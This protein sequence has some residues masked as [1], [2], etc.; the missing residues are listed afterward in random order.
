M[1]STT[2]ALAATTALLAWACGGG[3]ESA[4]ED[5]MDRM[6]EEHEGDRPVAAA[7]ADGE[8]P[9]AVE[10][11]EVQYASVG[12][13]EVTGYLATPEG[14]SD[15]VPG[16]IVIHEWWGLNDNIRAMAE[17]LA[18]EGY[19]ALAVDLYHGESATTSDGA[20]ELVRSVDE[21]QA[22]DNLRQAYD[23]L[24]ERGA[25]R[26]GAIGWCFGGGW[27]LQTALL[28][29][30]ELDADVIYY[31]RLV[32]TPDVL[33]ALEMPIMGHFGAEDSSIPPDAA[34]AFERTLDQV[35]VTNHIYV[36]EGAGHAFANPSG[37]RYQP[38]AA[39][40]AWERTRSFL[41][42]HLKGDAG[43]GMEEGASG[44]MAAN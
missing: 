25:P 11:R 20:M 14:A 6:S 32:T 28:H 13:Q 17:K 24:E 41:A 37:E 1:R 31:G 4:Q 39:K 3:Q 12:E 8:T 18:G 22:K 42:E 38:E 16:V 40:Q 35:G 34:R 23:F 27:S 19:A 30:K 2:T 9:Q 26:I 7:A 15:D 5:V 36:Y 21:Q 10:G 44:E 33:A 29:P 43:D